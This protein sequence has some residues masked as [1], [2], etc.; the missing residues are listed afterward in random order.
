MQRD[1][2]VSMTKGAMVMV[3]C[4]L[5]EEAGVR[6]CDAAQIDCCACASNAIEWGAAGC[7]PATKESPC[8]PIHGCYDLL[9][10]HTSQRERRRCAEK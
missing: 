8:H 1:H 9:L 10:R 5:L 2:V 7:I 6:C 4:V 3:S